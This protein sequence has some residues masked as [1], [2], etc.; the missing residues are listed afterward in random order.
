MNLHDW[1]LW[2]RDGV[3]FATACSFF[4]GI[5]FAVGHELVKAVVKRY[6][7]EPW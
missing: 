6:T 7:K 5:T 2:H 4:G 1:W 3:L